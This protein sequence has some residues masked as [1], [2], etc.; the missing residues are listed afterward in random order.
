[1]AVTNTTHFVNYDSV[2]GFLRSVAVHVFFLHNYIDPGVNGPT[3]TLAVEE[4]FY[5]TLPF[6][7]LL[8]AR[9]RSQNHIGRYFPIA[10]VAILIAVPVARCTHV[11][12]GRLH[13]DDHMLSHFRIDSLILGVMCQYSWR[14][15]RE[16]VTRLLRKRKVT[17]LIAS[18]L[19]LPSMFFS[20]RDPLMFSVGFSVLAIG[21]AL[22]LL[23]VQIH[24]FGPLRG[25]LPI[26]AVAAIGRNS[27]NIYL[28]HYF[29]PALLAVV[30]APVSLAI[31]ALPISMAPEAILQG[32]LLLTVAL[33]GGWLGTTLIE[34]PFLALRDRLLP[35][36]HTAF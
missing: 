14:F 36:R 4:H 17:W 9:S 3:W 10:A 20:R 7:L 13:P 21:Y 27:Y 18:I 30:F 5:T 6:L 35:S 34:K 8:T 2:G 24:G 25:S 28:W 16:T 12:L 15:H 22:I 32:V 11:I 31:A 26:R 19:V 29:S 1:L 33:A 23:D